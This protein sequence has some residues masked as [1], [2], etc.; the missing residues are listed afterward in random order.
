MRARHNKKRNTAFLYEMLVRQLTKA[1]LEKDDASRAE[2]TSLIKEHFHKNEILGRELKHY[3]ALLE[4]SNLK[5][6]VATKLLKEVKTDYSKLNQEEIFE[7]QTRLIKQINKTLSKDI[8]NVFIPN[9]KSL[10]TVSAIFSDNTSAK[11]RVLFEEMVI[12]SMSSEI[13]NTETES[14]KPIDN[15]VYHSFVKSFNEKYGDLHEEQKVLLNKYI[16]SF[17]DNG[18]DLKVFLNEEL[19]R[20]KTELSTAIARDEFIADADMAK[21]A[22]KVTGMLDGFKSSSINEV[23]V[24]KVLKVQELVREI[25]SDDN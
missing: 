22:I 16:A 6:R 2:L 9:Y 13:E 3:E 11:Q 15:I 20:L 18:L 7:K 24:S 5:S 4:T 8:W 25:Y 10:A 17:A 19:G 12:N 21:K 23:L 14:L 1:V